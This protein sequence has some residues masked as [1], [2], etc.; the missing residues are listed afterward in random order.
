MSL[1][2]RSLFERLAAWAGL[3]R[4]TM[5]A[6][7]QPAVPAAPG[8]EA[9][10]PGALGGY[11]LSG[12]QE[13]LRREFD[14][15]VIGGGIAGTCAAISAARNGARTAL[16]HERSMLGGNSSSE[17]RL[18]P[19]VSTSHNVWCKEAGI[20]DEIHV[21]ER[22]RNH[23]PYIEGLMNSV[24]DLVL[25]EW[26][27]REPNLTLFLN[28]T[29]REVEMKEPATILAVHAVQLGTERK[30]L[31]NAPLFI[32]CTGD[33]VIAQRAGAEFRWGMEGPAEFG[34]S[35]APE[36]AADQPQMGSTLFF[37]ARDAGV[38]VPFEAPSWAPRFPTEADLLGRNHSRIDG[39]YWWIEVGLPHHQIRGN[40]EIKHEALRQLLGVWDHIKN[41][42]ERKERARN[43][44]LDFVSF[45]P[46]KR[47]ARRIVGDHILT[48]RDLQDPPV[49]PDAVA[50]GCWYIDIHKPSGILARGKPNTK[51]DWEDAAVIPY[52]IPLRSCYS[53]TVSNLLMAG[54]PISTSYVAFSSTRVLRTGA[55]VGQGVGAA[56]A[57]CHRHKC[58]PKRLV[59]DHATELRAV[60]Q[61]QDC[62]LPGYGN[63]DPADLARGAT[64]TASSQ[65]PL[66]FPESREF[67][68]LATPAAQLFPVATDR[69]DAVDLLLRSERDDAMAVTLGLRG[70]DFVYDFRAT[71]D[72]ARASAV[73]PP[74]ANGYV[75]FD[76][77]RR[78]DPNRLYWVHLPAIPGLAWAQHTDVF[79]DP[80][81]VPVGT[82]PAEL[83]GPSRWHPITRGSS[84]CLR[85]TPGQNPYGPENVVR[86]ANRPDR[87][88]NIF[89][90]D[91]NRPLPAWLELRLPRPAR[92]ASVQITFDTDMNRH[93]R[94]PLYVYPDCVKRYDVLAGIGG[95]WRRVAGEAANY[96]RR[97]ELAFTPVTTDRVRIELHETNG[98]KSA[99]VYEIRLYG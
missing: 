88:P 52:G 93:S 63:D 87:W 44:G 76:F 71:E 54:R 98:A 62:Y 68:R 79:D 50:F 45:W 84:F 51:P 96:M 8:D 65:A 32:D 82:T 16:V 26:V 59:D 57:L 64:V 25:Y 78:V 29:A 56:A 22:R 61:R 33:G 20:L 7:A 5:S 9:R 28:T 92:I 48:Q 4:M 83:P 37:R 91:P 86:G 94:Q 97:R 12:R 90:S 34:E 81:R 3:G 58:T 38:P 85:L 42:C 73:V 72:V 1:H 69:I 95:G 2:R 11:I 17:V 77:N 27:V 60:L 40:E 49:H 47:E 41:H 74:R 36:H 80:A 21:E 46:Y 31:F 67:F 23:V 18:Y 75:R 10:V 99:R 55:I 53:K 39:G 14:V 89:V 35:Q 43:Y 70:A 24:W 19:E 13:V 66:D 6:A 15:V 30:F